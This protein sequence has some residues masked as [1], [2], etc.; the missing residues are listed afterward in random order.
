MYQTNNGELPR[1][2]ETYFEYTMQLIHYYQAI[3]VPTIR[4]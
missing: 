1:I 2:Y 4:E 3:G